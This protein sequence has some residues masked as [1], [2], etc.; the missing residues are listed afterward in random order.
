MER[1]GDLIYASD[2]GV[3]VA[4]LSAISA[5]RNDAAMER[6]KDVLL[7]TELPKAVRREAVRILSGSKSGA[8]LMLT[9]AEKQALPQDITL[10]VQERTHASSDEDVRL[11][12]EQI[13]PRDMT[14]EGKELPS[15]KDLLAMKGDPA[16]GHDAFYSEEK[17]QCYRCH[18]IKGEGREVGPDLTKIGEKL[19]RESILESILNPSAAVSHE[20]V[21][22]VVRTFADGYLSGYI[23]SE[24]D[25]EIELMDSGGNAIKI[26][27]GDILER[28]KTNVSLM[29]TGLSAGMTAAD[30]AD[31]VAFLSTLK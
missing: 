3:A 24:N 16:H 30:L 1:L 23:R 20:Y 26:A 6:F 25:D 10:D 13:L 5:V 29:P 19:S 12:A 22:W 7:N 14:V 15:M 4:A 18:M 27:Q 2:D 31:I 8:V 17:A 21:V 28:R 9:L 11:M